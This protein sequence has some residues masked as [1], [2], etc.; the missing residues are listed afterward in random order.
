MVEPTPVLATRSRVYLVLRCR[1]CTEPRYFTSFGRFKTFVGAL[2]RSDTVCH[3]FPTEGECRVY[4][5][6]ARVPF[7][8]ASQWS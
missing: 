7:P 5:L 1:G 4:A 2:E 3:G 6:A 8:E